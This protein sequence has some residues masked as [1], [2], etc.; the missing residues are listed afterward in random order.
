MFPHAPG[1]GSVHLLL[2]QANVAVHSEF[3]VHSGLHRGG[4]PMKLGRQ[5]Q[6]AMPP[7]SRHCELGP[8]GDG[9]HGLTGV[10]GGIAT[11][12]KIKC[13]IRIDMSK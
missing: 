4:E 13:I 8:Q 2:M 3:T 5:V 6:R 7:N 9:M 12:T 11:G 10:C 1:H